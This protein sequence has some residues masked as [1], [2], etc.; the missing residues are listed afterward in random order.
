MADEFASHG[1]SLSGPG[2]LH[3][4]L[5]ADAGN[6]LPTIPRA[7]HCLSSGSITLRDKA[8]VDVEYTLVAGL[9][10]PFRPVRVV[11]IGSGSFAGML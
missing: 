8:G 2:D 6:D 11:A 10:L 1:K 4:I 5:S 9:T 3:F 7:I